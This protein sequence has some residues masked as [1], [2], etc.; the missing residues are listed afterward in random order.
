MH[1]HAKKT[2]NSGPFV[3]DRIVLR[4]IVAWHDVAR[5][6]DCEVVHMGIGPAH[7]CLDDVMLLQQMHMCFDPKHRPDHWLDVSEFD[8]Q[9]NSASPA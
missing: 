7:C 8:T 2:K 9:P 3:D 4:V 1:H 5:T 6:C